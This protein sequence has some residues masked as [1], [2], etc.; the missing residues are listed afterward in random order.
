VDELSAD[1]LSADELSADEL[2]AD[3]LSA[4]DAESEA[5]VAGAGA[6]PE[7]ADARR[8]TPASVGVEGLDSDVDEEGVSPATA[9]G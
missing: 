5:E 4:E 8:C 9:V 1:E 6:G 2:S 7:S 3:E